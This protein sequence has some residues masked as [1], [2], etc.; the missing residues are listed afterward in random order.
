M[1]ES[2]PPLHFVTQFWGASYLKLY[3]EHSLPSLMSA[4][5]LHAL[6]DC[7]DAVYE[8]YTTERDW[9]ELQVH[10]NFKKASEELERWVTFRFIPVREKIEDS[11]V[12]MSDCHRQAIVAAKARDA[13]ILFLQPDVVV[14]D[15]T[16]RTVRNQLLGGRRL[17]MSPG[18]RAVR[19]DMEEILDRHDNK[20]P[21]REL[22]AHAVANLHPISK[23]LLWRN[24]RINSYC[25]HL[26][27]RVGKLSLYARCAHM[28]PLM[29]F[30][31]QH[32][33]GFDHTIDWDYFYRAC[34]DTNDWFVA[35]SSDEIC[36]VELSG[37]SKFEG[38]ENWRTPTPETVANFLAVA[39]EKPH[40]ELLA[41]PYFL[42]A[43]DLG[44]REWISEN[45]EAEEILRDAF[46]F[47]NASRS[48]KLTNAA[49][50]GVTNLRIQ[51]IILR[52]ADMRARLFRFKTRRQLI[53]GCVYYPYLLVYS[54]LRSV[55]R[56]GRYLLCKLC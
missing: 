47:L 48:E 45:R 19:E 51:R 49:I 26:Y 31:R 4:E 40:L 38:T 6:S 13:A 39:A 2:L 56:F 25:S 16:L 11:Y 33:C 43:E 9:A 8:I 10:P 15:G 1:R 37:R 14:G 42:Q 5:N 54:S 32:G 18:L 17:V 22:V 50:Q 12:M 46:A 20:L 36:L 41:T 24:S 35:S 27:W 53:G 34:P 3:A 55:W 52:L 7:T 30:P 29:V 21:V 44:I 23:A 28:H